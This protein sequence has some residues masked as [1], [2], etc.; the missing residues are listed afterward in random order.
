MGHRHKLYRAG[1][2]RMVLNGRLTSA[3][4]KRML[5][6]RK[7]SAILNVTRREMQSRGITDTG[8]TPENEHDGWS[9][10]IGIYS[11]LKADEVECCTFVD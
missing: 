7:F 4:S 9:F 8:T 2:P 1:L 3:T 5:S 11:F 6:V 10:P